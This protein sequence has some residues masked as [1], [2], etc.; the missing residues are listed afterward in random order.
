LQRKL[1]HAFEGVLRNE[2]GRELTLWSS[3]QVLTGLQ[4]LESARGAFQKAV[5][6]HP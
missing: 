5:A 4:R 1:P 3:G 2:L 6:I